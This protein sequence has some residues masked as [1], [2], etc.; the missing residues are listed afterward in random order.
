[1]KPRIRFTGVWLGFAAA[2]IIFQGSAVCGFASGVGEFDIPAVSPLNPEQLCLLRQ[3]ISSDPEAACLASRIQQD[4]GQDLGRPATP[5]KVINYEGLV[6]TDPRRIATVE[7]LRQMGDMAGLVRCW[8]ASAD[9]AAAAT[10]K[11]WII[12]W[13]TVYQPTGN[14]VNENKLY[15]LLVGYYSLR[16]SD[17]PAEVRA[18][19]DGWVANLGQRHAEAVEKS[20]DWTNRYTKH[21]R[22]VAICGLILERGDWAGV[23]KIQ[24]GAGQSSGRRRAE[25]L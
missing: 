11:E 23:D 18:T 1:M 16:T 4:T 15:P 3:L 12:G 22:L 13:A 2:C 14:D 10:L 5:L 24:G 6:N 20:T 19:M 8:Q 9:P 17:F 7:K 25:V 21:L